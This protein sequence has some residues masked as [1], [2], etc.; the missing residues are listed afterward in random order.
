MGVTVL[1]EKITGVTFVN[2]L[3]AICLFGADFNYWTKLIFAKRMMKKA[4]DEGG[5]PDVIYARA[6]D[7][8]DDASSDCEGG[9]VATDKYLK[10][11]NCLM[12]K[13]HV[14]K[15]RLQQRGT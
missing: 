3:R 1:L 10:K 15:L 4:R 6:G 2:K 5:L 12:S 14:S 9:V 7:H 11:D 8:C 13:T